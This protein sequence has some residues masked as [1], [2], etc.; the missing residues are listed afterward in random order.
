[1][2]FKLHSVEPWVP[3]DFNECTIVRIITLL[4]F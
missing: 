3:E 1:M 2:L 4:T